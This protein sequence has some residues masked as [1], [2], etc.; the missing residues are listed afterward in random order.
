VL[1]AVPAPRV[2]LTR[3]ALGRDA[4]RVRFAD[5]TVAG[6][7]PGRIIPGVLH[8]FITGAPGPARVVGEPVWA[9][10]GDAEY[11]VCVQHESLINRA[12][13]G[14]DAA[15]LCPYDAAALPGYAI[16]DA[17]RTHP[18]LMSDGHRRD[19]AGYLPPERAWP[20][21]NRPPA[22][23]DPAAGDVE[24]VPVEL[25]G[26]PGL[27]RLVG[28]RA[29]RAGLAADRV[30]DLL[31]AVNEAATNTVAHGGGTGALRVWA[32]ADGL[33]CELRDAGPPL[34]ELAG[35]IP[36]PPGGERGRGLILVNQLCDLVRV[37]SGPD[38]NVVRL[39]VRRG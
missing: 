24:E 8:P 1:V 7:N 18:V 4:D 37:F 39:H 10:R 21:F 31:L 20:V 36:P 2:A 16:D 27:R 12:F 30:T 22:P 9:G 23:P 28:E 26:L 32:D 15:V 6:R 38:G 35:R 19:S 14:R 5:M 11:P 29:A 3:S 17:A 34:A 13:E 25:A 33:V